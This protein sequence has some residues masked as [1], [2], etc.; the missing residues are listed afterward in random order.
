MTSVPCGFIHKGPFAAPFGDGNWLFVVGY[1]LKSVIVNDP[2]GDL[3]LISGCMSAA[4]VLVIQSSG[5]AEP[6]AV[7]RPVASGLPAT[8]G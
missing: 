5:A 3:D 2:N 8:E 1:T 4:M 7:S 6:D